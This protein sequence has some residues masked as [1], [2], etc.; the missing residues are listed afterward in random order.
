MTAF[1]QERNKPGGPSAYLNSTS[2]T[3]YIAKT[4]VYTAQTIVGDAYMVPDIL[5]TKKLA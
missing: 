4:A 1:L 3:L 2:N 5:Y